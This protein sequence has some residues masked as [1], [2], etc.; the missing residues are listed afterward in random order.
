MIRRKWVIYERKTRQIVSSVYHRRKDV[1]RDLSML[2]GYCGRKKY[3]MQLR[4]FEEN[5]ECVDR[6]YPKIELRD[7]PRRDEEEFDDGYVR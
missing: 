7:L 3:A 6:R 1:L 2:N 4:R 5:K